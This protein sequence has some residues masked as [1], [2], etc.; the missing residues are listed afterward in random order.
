MIRDK[1][2]IVVFGAFDAGKSSFIRAV[3]PASKHVEART[4]GG[5]TTVALDFGRVTIGGIKVFL[6]G[7]PGQERF[8]FVRQI[9]SRGM[10]GAIVVVDATRMLDPMTCTLCEWLHESAVPFII[11][12]N[13]C[14]HPDAR[15]ERFADLAD[16]GYVHCISARTGDQVDQALTA[17]VERLGRLRR[18]NK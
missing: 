14:D 11:L 7:T 13:K 17:F 6:F 10:D 4:A 15:P 5:T 3:D 1:L 9:L 2:K 8:E 16:N 18:E 12:V